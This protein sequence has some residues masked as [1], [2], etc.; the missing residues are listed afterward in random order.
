M[1]TGYLILIGIVA[2]VAVGILWDSWRSG[3][4]LC[5][6]L[7]KPYRN[8]ETRE[9]VWRQRYDAEA[10]E[11]ADAG[12][13]M[14]C[15]A[16]TFSPD[17]RYKFVPDDRIMDIYRGRYRWQTLCDSL[18]IES[19]TMALEKELGVEA[20]RWHPEVTLGEIVDWAIERGQQGES[21]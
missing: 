6:P 7:P 8:R 20:S 13:K 4:V 21:P 16:F 11:K 17:D 10:M 12:L 3:R 15:D 9:A 19:L 1:T 5:S 14:L 2:L 18:E